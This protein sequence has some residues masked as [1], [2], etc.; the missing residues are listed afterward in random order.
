MMRPQIIKNAATSTLDKS[1][2][3]QV[4][5]YRGGNIMGR[6]KT[7]CMIMVHAHPVLHNITLPLTQYPNFFRM[8]N[9]LDTSSSGA[10]CENRS[11]FLH[12]YG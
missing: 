10:S 9:V 6:G 8:R 11:L 5:V 1:N 3:R 7:A 4:Q 12:W 2:Q